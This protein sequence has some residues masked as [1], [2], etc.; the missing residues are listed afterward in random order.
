M[1]LA[2]RP[3]TRRVNVAW[4]VKLLLLS[5]MLESAP[6]YGVEPPVLVYWYTGLVSSRTKA[7]HTFP[8]C[9][10]RPDLSKLKPETKKYRNPV[11]YAQDLHDELVRDDLTRK[12][13]AARHGV[14]S[15]KITQWLCLLKLREK[16]LMEIECLGDNWDRQV[17]T[18]RALRRSRRTGN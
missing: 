17:V 3:L 4:T 2:S 1:G 15:D 8:V 13:L 5:L 10:R 18:E 7:K 6:V 12:Q 16:K 14:S 11:I 9:I